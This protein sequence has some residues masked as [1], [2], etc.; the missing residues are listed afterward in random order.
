[1][2]IISASIFAVG[3]GG[4][5]LATELSA[6]SLDPCADVTVGTIPVLSAVD[7]CPRHWCVCVSSLLAVSVAGTHSTRTVLPQ[8]SFAAM[9]TAAAYSSVTQQRDDVQP[10]GGSNGSFAGS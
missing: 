6:V 3:G 4:G 8:E 10:Q 2:E 1:M 5:V 7:R 9:A